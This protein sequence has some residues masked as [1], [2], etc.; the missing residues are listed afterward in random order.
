[1][2][3]LGA[4]NIHSKPTRKVGFV[5]K[6][7]GFNGHLK[8]DLSDES[9]LGE[10]LFLLLNDKFVPFQIEH[11]NVNANI[12][13]LKG[14]DSIESVEGFVGTTIVIL[15]QEPESE[16]LDLNGYTLIDKVS[17]EKFEIT[18]IVEMPGNILIEFRN[19]YKD[20]L[21]PFHEDIVESI[22]HENL[23]VY[24]VFPEGILDL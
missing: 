1:M 16:R 9:D 23:I 21:L 13:K 22:D 20:H 5:L 17:G 3:H 12:V 6:P 24:A 10:F 15:E 19:K 2:K 14:L 11:F 18:G 4:N 7:H 8:I